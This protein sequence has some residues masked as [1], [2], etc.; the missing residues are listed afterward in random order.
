MIDQY[1]YAF[2]AGNA[3]IV[4]AC[5]RIYSVDAP[6]D[7]E[8]PII[9]YSEGANTY[10]RTFDGVNPLIQSFCT[11]QNWCETKAEAESIGNVIYGQFADYTG[12]LGTA[13][14]ESVFVE[15]SVLGMEDE[16]KLFG[17]I[18]ELEIYYHI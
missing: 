2:L 14:A 1:L 17:C 4:A 7:V 10:Q 12:P 15:S 5:P 11:I 18:T 6:S 13:T 16:T 8:L 9:V 3:T